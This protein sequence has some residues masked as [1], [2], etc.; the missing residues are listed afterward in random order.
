MTFQNAAT[1]VAA[2]ILYF[3]RKVLEKAGGK[4][5]WRKNKKALK[6]FDF[7]AFSHGG[8]KRDRTAVLLN[9]IGFEVLDSMKFVRKLRQNSTI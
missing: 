9:A 4:K 8:D 5:F 2:L 3:V 6:P 1:T 7:K